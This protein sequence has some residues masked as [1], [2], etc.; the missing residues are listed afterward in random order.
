MHD[1]TEAVAG[2]ER[3]GW[4]LTYNSTATETFVQDEAEAGVTNLD[5]SLG[6]RLSSSGTVR[7]AVWNARHS[8]SVFLQ[9]N[10]SSPSTAPLLASRAT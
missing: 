2:L 3:A 1:G 9:D 10:T 6:M 7:S 8:A 5:T 4:R